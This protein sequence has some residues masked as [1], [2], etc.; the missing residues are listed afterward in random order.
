L[1]WLLAQIG[2][3]FPKISLGGNYLTPKKLISGKELFKKFPPLSQK[4][5]VGAYLRK[6]N[7]L[8]KPLRR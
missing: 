4:G 8:V 2:Q 6:F 3:G 1:G 5:G 7:T